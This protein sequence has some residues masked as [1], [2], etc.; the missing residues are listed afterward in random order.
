MLI[1]I[2]IVGNIPKVSFLHN[3]AAIFRLYINKLEVP[4][5]RRKTLPL[6]SG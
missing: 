4:A 1:R 6:W 3:R 2:K 5:F